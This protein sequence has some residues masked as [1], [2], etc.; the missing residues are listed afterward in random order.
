MLN[1]ILVSP[2]RLERNRP[3]LR[4]ELQRELTELGQALR[5]TAWAFLRPFI[6]EY[7]ELRLIQGLV[8]GENT[9]A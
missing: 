6:Q 1:K 7:D 3:S 8:E 5:G 9:R 4:E 2:K